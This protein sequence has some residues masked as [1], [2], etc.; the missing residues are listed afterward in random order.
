MIAG[1][2]VLG[3][4]VF[5]G[6]DQYLGS[7][8]SL[9]WGASVSLLSAPWLLIAL[10]AGWT[11]RDARRGAL[12]GLSATY[13]ALLGYML[14][15]LSPIEE[16]R[17]TWTTI[18]GF[19]RSEAPVLIGGLMTGPLFGWFGH[20]WHVARAWPGAVITAAA[21]CL[22]PLAESAARPYVITSTPVRHAE[23]AAG[24]VMIGYVLVTA[25][26]GHQHRPR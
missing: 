13:A 15:T 12:L 5:G 16:A 1:L 17:L 14:M 21:F 22:E 8:P 20:R 19:C 25:A 18:S 7:F 4:F 24:I 2:L 23:I 26:R 9:Q 11:Q 6:V 3:A 10:V